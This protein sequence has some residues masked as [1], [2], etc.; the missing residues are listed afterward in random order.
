MNL[1]QEHSIEQS[2][3]SQATP[4]KPTPIS[5]IAPT[6]SKHVSP[7]IKTYVKPRRSSLKV[8]KGYED[9]KANPPQDTSWTCAEEFIPNIPYETLKFK[10]RLISVDSH[11][12]IFKKKEAKFSRQSS[13]PNIL[14]CPLQSLLRGSGLSV[15]PVSSEQP[16]EK[17]PKNLT[18]IQRDEDHLKAPEELGQVRVPDSNPGVIFRPVSSVLS[19]NFRFKSPISRGN[20]F[21]HSSILDQWFDMNQEPMT[22]QKKHVAGPSYGQPKGPALGDTFGHIELTPNEE[23]KRRIEVF[24]C[25]QKELAEDN[26]RHRKLGDTKLKAWIKYTP[27]FLPSNTFN[28][29]RQGHSTVRKSATIFSLV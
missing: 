9:E 16:A 11:T 19:A 21:K 23:L 8:N 3:K 14:K 1:I 6:Q 22:S 26:E 5:M 15:G 28:A 24:K 27:L 29:C 13:S 10:N 18:S 7:F 17:S 12:K 25:K 4:N 2:G 20:I